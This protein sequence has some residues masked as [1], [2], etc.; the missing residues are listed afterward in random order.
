VSVEKQKDAIA[1]LFSL[2]LS[3]EQI[4]GALSLSVQDVQQAIDD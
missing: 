4:A 1:H 2:G 3:A